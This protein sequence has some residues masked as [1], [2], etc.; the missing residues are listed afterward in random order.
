VLFLQAQD[1][2]KLP[3]DAG[4]KPCQER[5]ATP[6]IPSTSP[7]GRH[8]VMSTPAELQT[9]QAGYINYWY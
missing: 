7:S 5:T 2:L 6:T 8:S 1:E 9:S 4:K 3:D